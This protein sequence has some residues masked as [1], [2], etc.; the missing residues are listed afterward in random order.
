M[1]G[2]SLRFEAV[3]R[4]SGAK[5]ELPYIANVY[6]LR[7]GLIVKFTTYYSLEEALEAVGLSE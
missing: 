1:I 5:V 2:T 3:G 6:E 4:G 7:D